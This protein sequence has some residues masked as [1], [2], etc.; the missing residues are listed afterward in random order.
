MSRPTVAVVSFRLGMLDGV[1]V[2][3]ESWS[4][5]LTELGYSLLWVAG[6]G[7]VDIQ[8]P[9]LRIRAPSPPS[10]GEVERALSSADLVIVENLCTIPL[11]VAAS[12][13][14]AEVIRGRPAILHHHDPSWQRSDLPDIPCLPPD[15]SA[16]RHVTLNEIT[17]RQM[18]DRGFDAVTIYGGFPAPLPGD[19][20]RTRDRLGL[21][22]AERVV[23]H[24][25]RAIPRKN[26]PAAIAVAERL[27]ATYWLTGPAEDGYD[28]ALE[29][30]LRAARCEVVHSPSPSGSVADA[31]AA[32]DAVVF[33][34]TWE[35]FGNP[36]IEAALHRRPVV[37]GPYPV[38]DELRA[39]GFSWFG[40]G[41]MDALEVFLKAPLDQQLEVLEHNRQVARNYFS[42]ERLLMDLEALLASAGWLP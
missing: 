12:E 36:P 8:L 37:V 16:W 21:D 11:N 10:A 39:K 26:V 2:V 17:R 28:G 6:E 40:L 15:D 33:P 1:S 41:D 34:S 30:L 35:G 25:V 27:S 23:L 31:Y 18:A 38:A 19:R 7:P 32:C 3:A 4:R 29:R 5:A 24:P 22:R 20:D 14:V 9:G 42:E 13:V